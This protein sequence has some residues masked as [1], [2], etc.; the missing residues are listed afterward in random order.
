MGVK[1][2]HFKNEFWAQFQTTLE[3]HY[4]IKI[5][6]GRYGHIK[7]SG[8]FTYETR[9]QQYLR[10]TNVNFVLKTIAISNVSLIFQ[11]GTHINILNFFSN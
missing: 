10:K 6:C 5:L 9:Q 3:T 8:V 4:G 11:A 7:Y 2:N 1:I